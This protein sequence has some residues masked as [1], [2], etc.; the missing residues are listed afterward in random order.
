[1]PEFDHVDFPIVAYG[2]AGMTDDGQAVL[3]Q[4]FTLDGAALH[5]S[6]KRVDL[7]KFVI[8]F[9]RMAANLG[10]GPEA[11][12]D[13]VQYQPIPISGMSAGELADGSGCVGVTVGSTEL[14]FQIPLARLSELAQTLLTVGGAPHDRRRMS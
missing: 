2:E 4:L 10:C 11:P 6:V 3:V 9:L 13:R 12:E 14:M 8:L 7:E 1:M 5:F